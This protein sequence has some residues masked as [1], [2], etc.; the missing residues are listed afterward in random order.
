MV[1]AFTTVGRYGKR[2]A[3]NG[4]VHIVREQTMTRSGGPVED[5][6]R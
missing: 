4:S 1:I 3:M 5:F 6:A 2:R